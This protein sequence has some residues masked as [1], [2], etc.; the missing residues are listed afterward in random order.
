MFAF[1]LA[2]DLTIR[3]HWLSVRIVPSRG[4][5][6]QVE[7]IAQAA[8]RRSAAS[9]TYSLGIGEESAAFANGQD[10]VVVDAFCHP[11]VL[12]GGFDDAVII[13]RAFLHCACGTRKPL[14]GYRLTVHVPSDLDGGLTDIEERALIEFG[15]R[16]GARTTCVLPQQINA[17]N[18]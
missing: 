10:V 17:V 15:M 6:V 8:L 1:G 9:V 2:V 13:V 4:E 16:L 14:F 7:G 11:R 18:L 5:A 12:I 3:K